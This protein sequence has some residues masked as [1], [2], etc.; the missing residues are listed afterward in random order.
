MH[1]L[2]RRS[3]ACAGLV[4]LA[5]GAAVAPLGACAAKPRSSRLAVDDIEYTAREL[6]ARLQDSDF[7]RDRSPES[8]RVV[9]AISKVENL[10]SDVI[11]EPDRWYMM[12]KVRDSASIDALRRLRNIVFVVPAEHLRESDTPTEFDRAYASGRRPTHEM[13]ATF[14]SAVRSA[15]VD[16][17]DAYLCELRITNID[18]RE[19]AW[20]GIVEFKKVAV[21]R[22]YD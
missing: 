12:V 9:I 17:T 18:T 5:L 1:T 8:E 19:V 14:R 22:A 3:A 10:S 16:R 20:T 7:L 4:A 13:T 15:G 21:G 11:P 6:A 2:V